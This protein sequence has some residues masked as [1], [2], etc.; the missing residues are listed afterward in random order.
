MKRNDEMNQLVAMWYN[1]NKKKFSKEDC[2]VIEQQ[3]SKIGEDKVLLLRSIK[4]KDP[5]HGFFLCLFLGWLGVHRFWI[6]HTGWGVLE[7]VTGLIGFPIFAFIDFFRI[8]R[9]VCKYNYNLIL[10]YIFTDVDT[11]KLVV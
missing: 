2:F 9:M 8:R 7:L 10:P 5:W 4:I 1:E 6:K 3:L 11:R